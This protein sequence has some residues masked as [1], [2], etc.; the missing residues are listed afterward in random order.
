MF[1]PS[2]DGEHIMKPTTDQSSEATASGYDAIA[3]EYVKHVFFELKAKPFDRDFLDRF[4]SSYQEG[5]LILDLGC[6]P[7]HIGRYL[8]DRGLRMCGFDLSQR[9]VDLARQLNPGMRFLR[10][11]MRV[12]PFEA[13]SVGGILAFYSIIH[14]SFAEVGA[15]FREMIR[16]LRPGGT[17]AI[18]FHVGDKVLHVDELWGTDTAL[19]F[20]FFEPA[21]IRSALIEAGFVVIRSAEREPYDELVEAQTRRC[22]MVARRPLR[23]THKTQALT[24]YGEGSGLDCVSVMRIVR[25][26]RLS[27]TTCGLPHKY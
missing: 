2:S 13:G 25:R 18:S 12:L 9:M 8:S 10:G 3:D 23:P 17:L 7:G 19:D 26:S 11:D 27:G 20:T 14:L 6:G 16:V 5:D 22:Y 1:N 4:A 21:Q 15:A 24:V